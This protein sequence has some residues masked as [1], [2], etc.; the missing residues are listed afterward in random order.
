MPM[1]GVPYKAK[2][3]KEQEE[4][5]LLETIPGESGR[6]TRRRTLQPQFILL[7]ISILFNILFASFILFASLHSPNEVAKRSYEFGFMTDLGMYMFLD[8]EEVWPD[9]SM[10]VLLTK[11]LSTFRACKERHWACRPKFRWRCWVRWRRSILCRP[12]RQRVHW[13]A[14]SSDWQGLGRAFG[15][16]ESGLWRNRGRSSPFHISMA[17]IR[18]VFQWLGRV[19]LASLSGID[20]LHFARLGTYENWCDLL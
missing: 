16:F 13:T 18:T 14:Y 6:L 15:G 20:I 8:V 3:G 5:N 1:F 2:M 10:N 19:P 11:T 9:W 12:R 17:R 4:E 7:I